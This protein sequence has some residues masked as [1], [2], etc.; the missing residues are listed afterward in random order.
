[1]FTRQGRASSFAS[2]LILFALLLTGAQAGAGE[3][4]LKLQDLIREAVNNNPEIHV[5]EA[6]AKASGYRIPQATS[7][8]DPMVMIGYENEGTDSIY[9][10]NRDTK[11]MPADSRWMFS[12]SQALPYP[13]KLVLKGDMAARDAESQKYLIDSARLNTIVRVKELY[14]DLFL[15]Y[16]NIDL[17]KDKAA[18]F[19]RAE[20]AALARYAAGMAPQQ[21]VLMAQTEKYMLLE[22]EEMFKQKIQ[23]LEAM[24]NAALGREVN[25]PLGGRPEKI[26]YVPYGYGLDELIKMSS[27]KYPLIKS[28]EKMVGAAQAKVAMAR[29]EFYPDFTVGAN[30]FARSA[31]FPD[32]WSLTTTVNVPLYYRKKQEPAILEAEAVLLEA[33]KEV[34]ASKLM[35]ASAL[36]DNYSMVKTTDSLMTLYKDGLI[37][38]SHQDFEL[39]LAGYVTGKVEAITV[40]SRLKPLIDNEMLYWVQFVERAKAIAR[41]DGIAVI[42][43]EGVTK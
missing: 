13:G 8:A 18:L 14:Y 3:Q 37:P 43:Y 26:P 17:L 9:S 20:D 1:M 12:V 40:V 4:T 41:I 11:G 29:K 27:E 42:D 33:K 32:M 22:R 39:A 28:R 34:E 10:F 30:Y 35:A 31:Q 15:T 25:A 6:R 2:S 21:E 19:V 16:T 7:L 5:S 23:S 38:K 24:L 36:R